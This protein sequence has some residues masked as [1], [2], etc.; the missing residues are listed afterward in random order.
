MVAGLQ[1]S[2]YNTMT[3]GIDGTKIVHF[4]GD[5]KQGWGV[6]G[7]SGEADRQTG[8]RERC[9]SQ[10]SLSDILILPFRFY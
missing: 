3:I 6:G 2:V 8:N 10:R 1:E 7:G 9:A 5:Q 4:M